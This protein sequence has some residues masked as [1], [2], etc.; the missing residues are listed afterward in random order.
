[1]TAYQ[2]RP[3][4]HPSQSKSLLVATEEATLTQIMQGLGHGNNVNRTAAG[5]DAGLAEYV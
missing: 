4:F 3:L 2:S 5:H 1:M